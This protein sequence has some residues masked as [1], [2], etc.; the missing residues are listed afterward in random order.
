[1]LTRATAVAGRA[2][3]RIFDEGGRRAEDGRQRTE[4]RTR[5]R[6]QMTPGKKGKSADAW[7]SRQTM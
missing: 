4:G 7:K 5:S 6:A 3:A 1:M 2:D